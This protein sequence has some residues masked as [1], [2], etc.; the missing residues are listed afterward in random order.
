MIEYSRQNIRA[1]SLLG[2]AAGMAM[3]GKRV[4]VTT[5]APFLCYRAADQ[6][7]HLMGNLN[8]DIKA[9]GTA[10]GYSAAISGPALNALS[11]IAFVRSIPNMIV[12]SPADCT[13]AMKM[14]E[15]VAD[16]ELS[17]YMRFCGLTNL[18]IVYKEDFKYEIGRAN[19]LNSGKEIAIIATGTNM[20]AEA[21][22]AAKKISE[23]NQ[24]EVTV[25]DMH[26]IKPLDIEL[27]NEIRDYKLIVT[28]EEHSII[29]GLG[30]AVAEYYSENRKSSPSL[31]RLGAP[32]YIQTSGNR[33]YML[34]QAGLTSENIVNIVNKFL[35]EN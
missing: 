1:W 28:V 14:I 33:E 4:F 16:I 6:V 3:E 31:M 11:D 10:A 30:S 27:L 23:A 24:K 18:P 5:Y 20:V 7:R 8:L 15:A 26:T 13:E 25:V 9:I 22:I 34:R 32:D 21:L 17:V 12:L 29:G 2:I 19:V 35:E